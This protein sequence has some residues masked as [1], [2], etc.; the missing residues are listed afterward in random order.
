M[1]GAPAVPPVRVLIVDD[2]PLVRRG[3]AEMLRSEPHLEISGEAGDAAGTWRELERCTPDLIILDLS[4]PGSDGLDLI[5]C[6]RARYP[7]VRILVVSMHDERTY[8]ER[9][10]RAGAQGFVHKHEP[11]A[12]VIHAVREALAGRMY[13]SRDVEERLLEDLARDR[14]GPAGSSLDTLSDRELEVLSLLGEGKTTAQIA[15]AL[16]LSPKTVQ[17]HREHLKLKLH[18]RNAPELVRYAVE[19]RLN[20]PKS[21]LPDG[22]PPA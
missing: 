17:S 20:A 13:V 18:L 10:L 7:A 6:V 2:H 1:S 15:E 16:H 11:P 14:P 22:G 19:A 3:L 12:T 21:G 9:A 4:L 5:K 8:A